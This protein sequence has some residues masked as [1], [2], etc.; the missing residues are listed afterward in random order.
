MATDEHRDPHARR[1]YDI[2]ARF[3]VTSTKAIIRD[4]R[5]QID[6]IEER[7][8]DPSALIREGI[9]CVKSWP[10]SA[11]PATLAQRF[12]A[13]AWFARSWATEIE[14]DQPEAAGYLR[15]AG[16][17]FEQVRDL[18]IDGGLAPTRWQRWIN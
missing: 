17:A 10:L 4:D 15:D 9:A 11:D 12:D 8:V 18:Y 2:A 1:L 7:P 6:R 3:G 14:H 16:A 13:S 5:G